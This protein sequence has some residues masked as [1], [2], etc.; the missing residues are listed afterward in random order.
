MADSRRGILIPVPTEAYP[1]QFG[2]DIELERRFAGRVGYFL[3]VGAA[4]GVLFSNTYRLEQVG[5]TGVLIEAQPD[6]AARAATA[7]PASRVVNCAASAPG[8][9]EH[10]VFQVAVDV[11]GLSA[12]QIT[13]FGRSCL[14]RWTALQSIR[15]I[16][17]PAR[18]ADSVLNDDPPTRVDFVSIDVEGH[19]ASV[20]R[21]LDLRRW[22]PCV[23]IV[24]RNRRIP[25]PAS[26]APTARCRVRIRDDNRCKRLVRSRCSRS[27]LPRVAPRD[28]LCAEGRGRGVGERRLDLEADLEVARPRHA[29]R[30]SKAGASSRRFRRRSDG[31]GSALHPAAS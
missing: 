19:E 18:T 28:V 25:D 3:D 23:V 14:D 10:V 5:W 15:E 1:A 8:G 26:N 16:T 27:A 2:E 12:I 29:G 31:R 21:G 7:R 9:P 13:E 6:E 11:P 17:V 30:P 24:E 22:K 20:L 4:D